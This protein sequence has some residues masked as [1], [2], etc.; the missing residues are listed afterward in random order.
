V[1]TAL[2]LVARLPGALFAV[3]AHAGVLALAACAAGALLADAVRG[4]FVR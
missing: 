2:R 3:V 4:A 1:L